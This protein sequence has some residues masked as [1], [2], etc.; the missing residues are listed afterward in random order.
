MA[1]YIISATP[2]RPRL[3]NGKP[4]ATENVKMLYRFE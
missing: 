2:F 3:E 1:R 4:T